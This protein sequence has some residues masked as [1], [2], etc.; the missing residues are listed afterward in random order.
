[1][2]ALLPCPFCGEEADLFDKDGAWSVECICGANVGVFVRASVATEAWN[3]RPD[4]ITAL[5][6]DVTRLTASLA[7]AEAEAGRLDALQYRF[8][9]GLSD[10]VSSCKFLSGEE[11]GDI[12]EAAM[13]G[14]TVEE[15][16][17][18]RAGAPS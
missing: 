15:I 12:A 13:T 11:L 10:V 4:A 5:R 9:E 14:K 6:A 17:A 16:E 18:R 3:T 7:A 8:Q 2:S 1:M